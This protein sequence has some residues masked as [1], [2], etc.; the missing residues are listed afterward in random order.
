MVKH[1]LH[2]YPMAE[3]LSAFEEPRRFND[4]DDFKSLLFEAIKHKC[5]DVF[6]QPNTPALALIHGEIRA[7]TYRL[8]DSSDIL[9]MVE[10]ASGRATAKTDLV[11]GIPVD[12]RYEVFSRED[13]RNNRNELMRY[14]FR[15][16]AVGINDGGTTGAQIVMRTI[17]NDPPTV[18][19]IGLDGGFVLDNCTPENGI[20]LVAGKTGSGKS[21]TFAAIMRYIL[22]HDTP[23]KG[24]IIT[25][26]QPIEYT[27]SGITSTHSVIT[28]SEVPKHIKQFDM[29]NEAAMRRHPALAMIGELRD[30]PT[31]QSAV[32]LSLT[33]HPVFG[34]VHSGTVS[35]VIKRLVTRFPESEQAMAIADLIETLRCIIAQ[36]LVPRADGKGLMAV[37]EY[38]KFDQPIRDELYSLTTMT[39]LT[40]R[41]Q[42]IVN[43]RGLSFAHQANTLL[44]QGKI[45]E[46]YARRLIISSGAQGS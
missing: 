1:A 43:E 8:M 5:S 39:L 15:V 33:G 3:K 13:E 16:N 14:G 46:Y 25:S 23:I 31:I 28:Q 41:I 21:T 11:Q 19:D 36:Q 24:N 38:L 45:T 44:E 40:E 32:E 26:E 37:R 12:S 34:T 22:E 17:P 2:S 30:G 27:Y 7:L 4:E 42:K 9:Q 20:V 6:I 29:A 35:T 10:W 18:D